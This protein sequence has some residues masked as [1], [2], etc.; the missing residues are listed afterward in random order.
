MSKAIHGVILEFAVEIVAIVKFIPV[1]PGGVRLRSRGRH[2]A[3][4]AVGRRRLQVQLVRGVVVA[5]HNVLGEIISCYMQKESNFLPSTSV[6]IE[7]LPLSTSALR[8]GGGYA[9]KWK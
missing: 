2:S 4:E 5:L 8:G 3:A 1:D 6:S 9:Q 7:R